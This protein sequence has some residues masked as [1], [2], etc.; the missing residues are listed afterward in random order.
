M[1]PLARLGG[2]ARSAARRRLRLV[3]DAWLQAR[4]A[5]GA[6][7]TR[8]FDARHTTARELGR[9]KAERLFEIER[10]YHAAILAESRAEARVALYDEINRA[11]KAFKAEHL[12]A[13]RDFGFEPRFIDAHT[14]LFRGH[15]VLD[16]G[17]GYG[18]STVHLRKH[19]TFAVGVDCAE[20]CI[21]QATREHGADPSLQFLRCPTLALPLEDAAVDAVYS[22]DVLEHLHP[23]D[24]MAHL[25]EARRVL[26][27]GGTYLLYTPDA[28]TG[29][30]DM[31]KA[32]WPQSSG[33][34]PLGAHIH[35]YTP[36]ELR[37]ALLRSGFVSVDH[38]DPATPTLVIARKAS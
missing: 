36:D 28:A 24:A 38:P 19:A 17:C 35:E 8:F 1:R 5:G 6:V 21:E 16:F 9:E 27:P 3:R 29:P 33:F 34:A 15:R 7:T 23:T 12:P 10:H 31:T 14:E 22:N 20:R 26:R 30:H 18:S 2:R 32:F 37:D 13:R 11:I 25:A 4:R